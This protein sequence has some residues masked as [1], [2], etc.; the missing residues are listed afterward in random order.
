M[1]PGFTRTER[2]MKAFADKPP[3][4]TESPR[5]TGRAVAALAADPE[6]M[7]W[8]GRVLRT[9]EWA[10]IYGFTDVDGRAVPPFE[11]PPGFAAPADRF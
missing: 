5:Y 10:Q 4:M 3:P 1:L 11:M 2:V 8:T 9:G 6:I 7:R